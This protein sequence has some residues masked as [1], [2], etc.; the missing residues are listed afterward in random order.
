MT[1]SLSDTSCFDELFQSGYLSVLSRSVIKIQE[2]VTHTERRHIDEKSGSKSRARNKR[3]I[4]KNL[5][6]LCMVRLSPLIGRKTFILYYSTRA[7][8]LYLTVPIV[9]APSRGRPQRVIGI[10]YVVDRLRRCS[11]H[12]R[13][14]QYQR[15]RL[16]QRFLSNIAKLRT[17]R[18][19][20]SERKKKCCKRQERVPQKIS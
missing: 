15:L 4:A 13:S 17:F 10:R 20:D 6:I 9:T 1:R 7:I 2:D 11:R 18:L 3:T 8:L 16:P 14:L 5:C 19:I 12:G